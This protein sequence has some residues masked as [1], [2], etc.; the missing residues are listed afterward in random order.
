MTEPALESFEEALA[1]ADALV[2]EAPSPLRAP[3]HVLPPRAEARPRLVGACDVLV[4]RTRDGVL[5]TAVTDLDRS[6]DYSFI[7]TKDGG[8]GSSD[9]QQGGPFTSSRGRSVELSSSEISVERGSS[10]R[11]TLRLTS[12]GRELCRRTVRS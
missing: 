5:L 2:S 12:H 10:W 6:G 8:S 7:V 9:I 4:K 3:D 11:A 1:P